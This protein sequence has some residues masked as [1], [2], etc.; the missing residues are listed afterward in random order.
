MTA[1]PPAPSRESAV[2][3]PH[4]R[5]GRITA[6]PKDARRRA[7][8]RPLPDPVAIRLCPVPDLAPPYDDDDG[9]D[10]G[11]DRAET[12]AAAI[13]AR[14]GEPTRQPGPAPAAGRASQQQAGPFE[15]GRTGAGTAGKTGPVAAGKTGPRTAG[16]TGP[17][18]VRD[19]GP[20][21]AR[22]SRADGGGRTGTNDAGWPDRF[23]QVL[24]ETLGGARPSDQLIPWTTERARSR[25]RSLG[26]ML[27]ASR[28]RPRV[29][30]VVT[31][32]PAAGVVEMSV[33]AEFGGAVRALAV[34]LEHRP[35]RPASLGRPA[36]PARWLCTALEVA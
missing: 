33:V 1:L 6:Q 29:Q 30:R 14:L 18:T 5:T 35:P 9:Y 19:T 21:T 7:A 36:R 28:Q 31:S 12:F 34:R 10:G 3:G 23:A 22:R 4:G 20:G 8:L 16:K 15:A 27:A 32:R 2:T 13:T 25:I 11:A 17:G 26:P 24:T